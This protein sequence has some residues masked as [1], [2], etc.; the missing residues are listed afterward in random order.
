[1]GII[2]E[3][4]GWGLGFVAGGGKN[5]RFGGA[6]CFSVLE[7]AASI[8][9]SAAAPVCPRSGCRKLFFNFR[10]AFNLSFPMI[11]L[12]LLNNKI[13]LMFH[14]WFTC[15]CTLHGILCAQKLPIISGIL[16]V[17]NHAIV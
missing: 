15:S 11:L 16:S 14:K 5:G 4:G 17:K 9:L 1:M 3:L 6:I 13:P 12:F 10:A 7:S 2:R 8:H